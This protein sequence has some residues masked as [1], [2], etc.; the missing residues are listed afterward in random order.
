MKCKLWYFYVI[1][2]V[3]YI[4]RAYITINKKKELKFMNQRII[5]PM[6]HGN[7]NLKTAQHVFTSGFIE[8]DCK[9]VL[10]DYLYYNG[11][12]Y[13]LSEQR[14]PYMRDKTGD[15]RF[16]ILTLFGIAMEAEKR[17]PA[18][19]RYECDED[20]GGAWYLGDCDEGDTCIAN[21][22]FVNAWMP[23]PEAYRG[24]D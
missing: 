23:L 6:D 10:G 24:E 2:V 14:I 9:P 13:T 20:G 12:Y 3:F 15:E 11:R 1:I 19:G 7:R 8:S 5:I 4:N 16:F 22:L 17:L 18:I 21:D